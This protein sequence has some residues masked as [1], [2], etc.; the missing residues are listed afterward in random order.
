MQLS[1]LLDTLFFSIAVAA[2]SNRFYPKSSDDF[3]SASSSFGI[4]GK[5]A[6]FDYII[7]GGGT[8]G[9]T[10]AA[11]LAQ[12]ANTSVA[13]VEAGGFY[14]L[15]DGNISIIPADA[16]WYAGASPSDVNPNVDWGFVTTPQAVSWQDSLK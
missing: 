14:E 10:V 11:R 7:I 4:P 2:S 3:I 12:E 15:G 16:V 9:L 6:T 8:A 5:N 13:V 1:L